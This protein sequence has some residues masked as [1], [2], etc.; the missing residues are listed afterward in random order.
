MNQSFKVAGLSLA[1][2]VALHAAGYKLPQQSLNSTALGAASVAY[3]NGADATY[4]NPANMVWMDNAYHVEGSLTYVNLPKV[5]FAGAIA[6]N[7]GESEVENVLKPSLHVVTKEYYENWRF[8]FSAT[9]PAGL[10]KRWDSGYSKAFSENFTLKVIEANPTAAYK[11]NDQLAVGFG[12][13]MVYTDGEVKSDMNEAVTLGSPNITRDLTGDSID[14]GYNVALSYR[15][16]PELKLAATYR[17]KVDLTVEGDAKLTHAPAAFNYDDSASVTIPL[18]ATLV[19]AAAY[20]M[21]RTTVEFAFERT[22]WSAYKELDFDYS[23]TLPGVGVANSPHTIFDRPIAKN[24]KDSNTYR[25][26]ITHEYSDKLTLMAGYAYD[27]TPVPA[28]TLGFE[29]P[30]SD[31]NIYSFGFTYKMREDITV[32]LAYLYSD[33]KE[34]TVNHPENTR[35]NGKFTGSGAH[36]VT[37]GITYR[38]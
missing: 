11:I 6:L 14:Y 1:C 35:V 16:T 28:S 9:A 26:G 10:S 8:G 31:A 15:P 38:F 27:E 24:W 18:P 5:K 33:K 21:N 29:Q 20:T 2:A 22:Y 13:R 3:T 32:G 4:Y 37:T 17:S 7:S 12:V 25:L 36:L 34:R 23:T 30:D 19:L